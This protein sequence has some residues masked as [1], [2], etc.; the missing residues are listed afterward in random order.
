MSVTRKGNVPFH[1]SEVLEVIPA[2]A[3]MF[4]KEE[5]YNRIY[6]EEFSI[7]PIGKNTVAKKVIK[8]E[9]KEKYNID[10]SNLDSTNGIV[11]G[12]S[13]KRAIKI[14]EK[15][16]LPYT[17]HCDGYKADVICT[18]TFDGFVEGDKLSSFN[19]SFDGSKN[20]TESVIAHCGKFSRLVECLEE[21]KRYRDTQRA[22][23]GDPSGRIKTFAIVSPENPEGALGKTDDPNF[24]ENYL[25]YL[26]DKDKGQFDGETREEL[27]KGI[28]RE[29]DRIF[30]IGRLPYV[31]LIGE[32]D[33]REESYMIFNLTPSDAF[34]IAHAYG[35]ESFFFGHVFEDHSDIAYYKTTN[36]CKSYRLVEVSQTVSD[37]TKADNYFSKFGAKFKINMNE[38]DDVVP[39]VKNPS[40]FDASL[41]EGL[42]YMM[43]AE[44]RK[45]IPYDTPEDFREE[46]SVFNHVT[47]YGRKEF[48]K[49]F[50]R[51]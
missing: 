41:S 49:I 27:S 11:Y 37:E 50:I 31:R 15:Y 29:G 20:I 17:I 1:L 44:A 35:Q 3:S 51:R 40:A 34:K 4:G 28:R 8:E 22:L 23:F 25:N 39:E 14:C 24:K 6:C 30:H 5:R 10:L 43:K 18:S 2:K 19:V 12:L 45:H 36:F 38:F 48:P 13:K 21:S 7:L 47:P 46:Y 42:S 33:G 9:L 32:Y 26:G 16:S